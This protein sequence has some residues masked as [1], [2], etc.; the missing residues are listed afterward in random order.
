MS[1]N[2]RGCSGDNDCGAVL[3]VINSVTAVTPC[4]ARRPEK[5]SAVVVESHLVHR[6]IR[7][8]K[9]VRA[10]LVRAWVRAC[11]LLIPL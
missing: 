2:V 8:L 1:A 9:V 10:G 7:A 11:V 6:S 5:A 4:G 3:V